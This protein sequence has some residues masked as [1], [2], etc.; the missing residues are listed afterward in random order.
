MTNSRLQLC[1]SDD[2]SNAVVSAS[3]RKSRAQRARRNR[4]S[5][6]AGSSAGSRRAAPIAGL[7]P[8]MSATAQSSSPTNRRTRGSPAET[9]NS[10]S[11]DSAASR[12]CEQPTP[13]RTH[14]YRPAAERVPG[15]ASRI[16]LGVGSECLSHSELERPATDRIG[17]HPV[18]AGD[19]E[20]REREHRGRHLRRR[21]C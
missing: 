20:E 3:C 16:R 4:V 11:L 2:L 7:S 1:R 12:P 13:S 6:R 17:D 18:Q 15:P 10:R 9:P 8:A 5:R 14:R 19:G 21:P